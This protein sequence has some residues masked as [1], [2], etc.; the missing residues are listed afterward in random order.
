MDS[1]DSLRIIE[2]KKMIDWI[3]QKD[4]FWLEEFKVEFGIFDNTNV[5]KRS[6]NWS[7]STYLI[8]ILKKG[9]YIQCCENRGGKRQYIVVSLANFND[10][11]FRDDYEKIDKNNKNRV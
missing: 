6:W 3:N 10:F 2:I 7:F 1:K 4:L 5:S 11:K 9:N 8:D